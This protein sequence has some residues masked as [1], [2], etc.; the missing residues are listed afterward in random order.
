MNVIG[1]NCGSS[2]YYKKKNI[3]Y[4]NPFT[5]AAVTPNDMMFLIEHYDTINFNNFRLVDLD[6]ALFKNSELIT[7]KIHLGGHIK[8]INVDNKITLYYTHYLSNTM[9]CDKEAIDV[10]CEDNA[11]Y[12]EEKYV[13]RVKRMK[14]A[15]VFL[16]ITYPHHNWTYDDVKKLSE[17][18]TDKKIILITNYDFNFPKNVHLIKDDLCELNASTMIDKHFDEINSDIENF[19][20]KAL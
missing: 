15:P 7:K 19:Y 9:K 10:Y 16:I 2:F 8:G 11:K 17:L 20:D 6:P 18:E 1:N 3:N 14:D 12:V 5:W 4:T 13:S